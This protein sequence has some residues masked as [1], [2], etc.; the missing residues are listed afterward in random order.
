MVQWLRRLT[1]NTGGTGSILHKELGSHVPLPP[2]ES[3]DA[4]YHKLLPSQGMNHFV[5]LKLP[6]LTD[7]RASVISEKERISKILTKGLVIQ[8][9]IRAFLK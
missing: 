4:K 3:K 6:L 5:V 1:S 9:R 7:F 8:K 2:K